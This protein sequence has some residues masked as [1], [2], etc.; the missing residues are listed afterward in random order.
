MADDQ[1][2]R[3]S[4]GATVLTRDQ[5]VTP[6]P[7]TAHESADF[8]T[9]KF[10]IDDLKTLDLETKSLPEIYALIGQLLEVIKPD[11]IWDGQKLIGVPLA[12]RQ[13]TNL[14]TQVGVGR[15][16]SPKEQDNVLFSVEIAYFIAQI[17]HELAQRKVF[18]EELN[19]TYSFEPEQLLA[20]WLEENEAHFSL[21]LVEQKDHWTTITNSLLDGAGALRSALAT[22]PVKF[23][24]SEATKA[25]ETEVKA[26]E[27]PDD[28]D[29]ID[30]GD[31]DQEAAGDDA[32][33]T[34]DALPSSEP[35]TPT[36][37]H[38]RI[39]LTTSEEVMRSFLAAGGR[40]EA[41]ASNQAYLK[42]LSRLGFSARDRRLI[43][44][45]TAWLY[46]G[47]L[48]Q[49]FPGSIVNFESLDP[50]ARA[51]INQLVR[52][53]VMRL[54]N[55]QQVLADLIANP[56]GRRDLIMDILAKNSPRL[57]VLA[58]REEQH[59]NNA[60]LLNSREATIAQQVAELEQYLL[61]HAASQGAALTPEQARIQAYNA[62]SKL[63]DGELRALS[64]GVVTARNK[65]FETAAGETAVA[66]LAS[67]LSQG[68]GSGL[69]VIDV[70]NINLSLDS[71]ALSLIDK[72]LT[73]AQVQEYFTSL[74]ATELLMLL[75]IYKSNPLNDTYLTNV[76]AIRNAVQFYIQERVIALNIIAVSTAGSDHKKLEEGELKGK[77]NQSLTT[78]PTF[79]PTLIAESGKTTSEIA[80]QQRQTN[81]DRGKA[82]FKHYLERWNMLTVDEQ[83]VI[84]ILTDK[85]VPPTYLQQNPPVD[86]LSPAIG[87]IDLE[88]E[89]NKNYFQ[90]LV[91][92]FSLNRGAY[93]NHS[94]RLQL[95]DKFKKKEASLIRGASAS[96]SNRVAAAKAFEDKYRNLWSTLSDAEKMTVYLAAGVPFV[97]GQELPLIV[98][99]VD[100]A[101]YVGTEGFR[102]LT[103]V[104]EN[105][106]EVTKNEALQA[107]F[108]D[109][110]N[111]I[112]DISTSQ[113]I[114]QE[115]EADVRALEYMLSAM[116]EAQQQQLAAQYGFDSI[117]AL[118]AAQEA[119]VHQ[120]GAGGRVTPDEVAFSQPDA[121]ANLT[122]YR[123]ALATNSPL[124]R[125]A[126]S[127][128]KFSKEAFKQSL[129]A[130]DK[131][132]GLALAAVP[133]AGV[134]LSK[135]WNNKY[136]KALFAIPVALYLK[137]LGSWT[138]MGGAALGGAIG[139][140]FPVF[141]PA[142][143]FLFSFGG[144]LLGDA[145]NTQFGGSNWFGVRMPPNPFAEPMV[146]SVYPKSS[147]V[148]T[149]V[150]AT[151]VETSVAKPA[152]ATTTVA[153]T[154]AAIWS[155]ASWP[156]YAIGGA[157]V[158]T[159]LV[160][161][162]IWGAFLAPSPTEPLSDI[163]PGV[164]AQPSAQYVTVEKTATPDK[165][166]NPGTTSA[167]TYK[168]TITPKPGNKLKINGIS[169]EY[170][171]F[172]KKPVP[173][174][175]APSFADF[176]TKLQEFVASQSDPAAAQAETLLTTT[177][178]YEY[179]IPN[180]IGEDAYLINKI[181]LVF[182]V[183]NYLSDQPI[184]T[185]QK[186]TTSATVVIGTP[187]VGCWPVSGSITSL[188]FA[189]IPTHYFA[190]S[191]DIGANEGEPVR[192]PFPGTA[193][194]ASGWNDGYGNLVRL[195]V[196][197]Q[198]IGQGS[199]RLVFYFG[200]FS[201]FSTQLTGGQAN[202]SSGGVPVVTG[203]TLGYVGNSGNSTGPHLHYELYSNR[204]GGLTGG[205][206]TS[207]LRLLIPGGQTVELETQVSSCF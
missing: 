185:A 9:G 122:A 80:S 64:A 202:C 197:G 119:Q 102:K 146:Q 128:K 174:P 54:P 24:A 66:T 142:T 58:Q 147:P 201:A 42:E 190:D 56:L 40:E 156:V 55:R 37:P 78:P 112:G 94:K 16:K 154:A 159:M 108:T 88:T 136:T 73:R 81:T 65:I 130:V 98:E 23:G 114:L 47:V 6:R 141:G 205:A 129:K 169:D 35:T 72:G 28:D 131:S 127:G 170:S 26:S 120:L 188:P 19:H 34:T 92:E 168:I 135:I 97:A 104:V 30:V 36:R 160:M 87:F 63:T 41:K 115:Q 57:S 31:V 110:F 126:R 95:Q 199:R 1:V 164:D 101:D 43:I 32:G 39:P 149:G 196:D 133:G 84:C 179:T 194:S 138:G 204:Y 178:T 27:N 132:I 121:A 123:Q 100:M 22:E 116:E 198:T 18:T 75:G 145:L 182:D 187:Q 90:D 51:Q 157:G 172:G 70:K 117:E 166:E 3:S 134:V 7:P 148:D 191:F 45:Q 93:K 4:S 68:I 153:V 203:D 151:A 143:P 44:D 17:V 184:A 79:T 61:T 103:E 96:T 46:S 85:Q 67:A 13:T 29:L 86:L 53:Y 193:C 206:L 124:P 60:V 50:V 165:F 111:Q 105:N 91:K 5:V 33:E 10:V 150:E 8:S 195:F 173:S 192:A 176:N 186:Y 167:I 38:T 15:G 71:V 2:P 107:D 139:V 20:D 137:A 49:V 175:T 59:F 125:L 207:I 69:E 106:P 83:V 76:G 171:S 52:D 25:G 162:V 113:A 152:V 144:A 62:L 99:F 89:V 48:A 181:E 161:T 109:Y 74:P 155:V 200:H 158:M 177:F 183:Y 14:V 77:V 118:I 12:G 140:A 21:P 11:G 180:A 189:G 163:Q 82:F